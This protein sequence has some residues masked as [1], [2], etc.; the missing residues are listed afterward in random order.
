M[1][2]EHLCKLSNVKKIIAKRYDVVLSDDLA[3]EDSSGALDQRNA[4]HAWHRWTLGSLHKDIAHHGEHREGSLSFADFERGE[5][6]S[7]HEA[8][9]IGRGRCARDTG[10]AIL[11]VMT[12]NGDEVWIPQSV[13]HDDSEVYGDGHNGSVVVLGWWATRHGYA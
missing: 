1:A 4:M 2:N 3:N 13:I 10:R 9:N 6:V 11:V 7:G 8:C 12:A 5:D